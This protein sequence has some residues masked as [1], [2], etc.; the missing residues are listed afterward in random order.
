MSNEKINESRIVPGPT[1]EVTFLGIELKPRPRIRN[2]RSG[3][4]GMRRII[5]V[6]FYFA[7]SKIKIQNSKFKDQNYNSKFKTMSIVG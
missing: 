5:I 1:M 6:M 4:R 7:N 3:K 2:P